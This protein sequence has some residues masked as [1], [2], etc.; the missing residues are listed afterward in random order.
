MKETG[1]PS[2]NEQS[3]EQSRSLLGAAAAHWEV[4]AYALLILV[5]AAMRFWDLGNRAIGYDESLHAYYSFRFAE[6]LGFQHSALTH[7]P[8]QFHAIAAVFFL[9]G[10]SDYTSRLPAAIFG[11]ALVGLPY[12]LRSRLGRAG[13]LATAVLLAF[14][15]M[16]LFYSRYARNDIFMAVWTLGLAILL[17]RYIDEGKPRYLYL[18]ALTL[19]LAF[20]TKE[21]T[22]FVVGIWGSY[23]MIV[24]AA[25]WIPWLLR[26]S[27][28]SHDAAAE[29]GGE[30][31]YTPGRG[32]GY[33]RSRAPARLS[34]FSRPGVFLVLL[35]TLVLPQTSALISQ[36]Q[37]SM[38][39]YGVVLASSQPACRRSRRRHAIH[40]PGRGH[41]QGDGHRR[42][43][44]VPGRL[45]LYA[46]GDL[47][48]PRGLAALRRHLLQRVAAPVYHLLHK[49]C[50]PGQWNVAVPGIL[51]SAAG[52]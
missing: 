41:N 15:P 35:A 52:C 13:A 6:G 2:T 5:A 11:V 18:A 51:D 36:F 45:V 47:L 28:V 9:F 1:I 3:N 43:C 50:G 40:A 25:D 34:A 16:L 39:S 29:Q 17:W 42:D 21:T 49:R 33:W 23:L 26:Q 44:G 37:G 31:G 46:G 8:F 24:A 19:A 32:Y 4:W 30:Y 27:V 22:F 38:K 12:F 7:G 14:S 20:A 48:E 10:D